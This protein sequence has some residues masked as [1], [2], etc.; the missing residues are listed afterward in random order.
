MSGVGRHAAGEAALDQPESGTKY[1]YRGKT[2]RANDDAEIGGVEGDDGD[3][4]EY[5]QIRLSPAMDG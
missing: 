3:E 1:C 2:R 4:D 5:A